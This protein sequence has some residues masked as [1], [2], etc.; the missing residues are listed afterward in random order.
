M[1][2][3]LLQP[4]EQTTREVVVGWDGRMGT[5]YGLAIGH[6][7]TVLV[8]RGDP[9]DRIYRPE[10]VLDALRPYAFV[11]DGLASQLLHEALAESTGRMP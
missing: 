2:R 6:D 9:A 4:H 5:F 11:P 7:N 10:L 8:G 1:S 3:H